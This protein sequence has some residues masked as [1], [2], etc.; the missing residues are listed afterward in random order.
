MIQ[1]LDYYFRNQNLP[2]FELSHS[3]DLNDLTNKYSE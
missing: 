3:I 1:Q 2:K